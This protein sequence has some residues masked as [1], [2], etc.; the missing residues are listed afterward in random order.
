MERW[1]DVIRRGRVVHFHFADLCKGMKMRSLFACVLLV[2]LPGCAAAS[3][4]ASQGAPPMSAM[5][6]LSGDEL[7]RLFSEG[8]HVYLTPSSAGDVIV[9][10]PPGE[11]FR[12][13][14]S[15]RRILGRTGREGNYTIEDNRLCVWGDGIS[16]QCRTLIP[17]GDKNYLLVDVAD[18]SR[19]VME[20]S[21]QK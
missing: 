12:P 20:L 19:A 18:G 11:L 16:K 15:Y 4:T 9:D 7:R 17:Q 1:M 3:A 21:R 13:G 8:Y 6:P 2:L 14:G 10:H 5:T